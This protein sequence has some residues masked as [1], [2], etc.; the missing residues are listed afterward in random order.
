MPFK[1]G[2]FLPLILLSS[3]Q[4]GT[5]SLTGSL[6][7]NEPNDVFLYEFS[8]PTVSDLFFQSYGFG[9]GTNAAGIL[10][11]S[12][13]FDPYL[14]IFVGSGPSA[15]FLASNDDGSCPAGIPDPS[16]SDPTLSLLGVSAGTYTLA[17]T[18]FDNFSISENYGFG[19]LGDGFTGLG[20]YWNTASNETRSPNFALDVSSSAG[21][22][23]EPGPGGLVAVAT[24]VFRVAKWRKA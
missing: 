8:V 23:P 20:D 9:G 18:V 11:S 16:C 14:S 1:V 5:V 7:P 12:G 3:L 24:L 13:G 10:I 6:D 4:A 21:F 2:W 22:T 15:L 17:L 19:S